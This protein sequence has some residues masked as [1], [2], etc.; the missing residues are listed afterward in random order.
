MSFLSFDTCMLALYVASN[1]VEFITYDM[2]Y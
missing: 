2:A 1:Q